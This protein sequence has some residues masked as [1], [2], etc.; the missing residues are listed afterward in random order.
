MVD[1]NYIYR[2]LTGR[3]VH[4]VLS[5]WGRKEGKR[6]APV[7]APPK[8]DARIRGPNCPLLAPRVGHALMGSYLC[9]KVTKGLHKIQI[10]VV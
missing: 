1:A 7:V 10:A 9:R 6:S 2:R 4:N 8:C 5:D 3:W